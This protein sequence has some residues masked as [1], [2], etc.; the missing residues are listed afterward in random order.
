MTSKNKDIVL[1]TIVAVSMMRETVGVIDFDGESVGREI[2]GGHDSRV[3]TLHGIFDGEYHMSFTSGTHNE[4][5]V[6]P[7]YSI[8][9]REYL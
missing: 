1:F 2:F 8:W 6:V 3:H 9:Q 7:K 5:C 4:T